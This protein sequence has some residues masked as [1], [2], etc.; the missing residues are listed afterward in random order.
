MAL[1]MKKW[2]K[3]GLRGDMMD[4]YIK[5]EDAIE[6]VSSLVDTMSVCTNKDECIGMKSMKSRAISAIR[7]VPASDVRE[8]V[9]GEWIDDETRPMSDP[10][11]TCSNCGSVETPLVKWRFCPRCGADM[12]PRDNE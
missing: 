4:D 7:D 9:R 5:R 3:R 6:F 8:N 11:L 10:R 2:M 12:R 1:S